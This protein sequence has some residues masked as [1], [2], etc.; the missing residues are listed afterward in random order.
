MNYQRIANDA[1]VRRDELLGELRNLE[2]LIATATELAR[3]SRQPPAGP[4]TASAAVSEKGSRQ[5]S[6]AKLSREIAAQILR[7]QGAPMRTADLLPILRHRGIEVGGK[8][9][10]ATLAARLSNSKMFKSR[11]RI[12]WWFAD[13][14]LPAA[15]AIFEESEGDP[16]KQPPSD[17]HD[18][19]GGSHGTALDRV[20]DVQ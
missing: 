7:E 19:K 10:V 6:K 13:E 17:S 20:D 3:L 11:R 5:G 4:H 15:Y 16:A 14:P 9:P 12:G 8:D 2:N 18:G 1:K